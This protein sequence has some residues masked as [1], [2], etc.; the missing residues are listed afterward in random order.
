MGGREAYPASSSS[1]A[2]A[3]N[4]PFL[5]GP[6]LSCVCVQWWCW[7]GSGVR[8]ET[9]LCHG[10]T[11]WKVP[12]C[13]GERSKSHSGNWKGRGNSNPAPFLKLWGPLYA[14]QKESVRSC[15][16]PRGTPPLTHI[17][18][19]TTLCLLTLQA[20]KHRLPPTPLWQ[21]GCSQ[22]RTDSQEKEERRRTV[23]QA[24]S[25]LE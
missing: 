2:R 18:S 4:P 19:A 5:K 10:C 20:Q 9:Y 25:E 22:W 12:R 17:P 24:F 13:P 14:Q 11:S 7:W 6:L 1:T 21:G 8:R 23:S 3:Q 16:R 15:A